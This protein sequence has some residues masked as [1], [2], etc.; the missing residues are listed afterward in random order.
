MNGVNPFSGG[1][2]LPPVGTV[3]G[4]P[5]GVLMSTVLPWIGALLIVIMAWRILTNYL[6][7]NHSGMTREVLFAIVG[8]VFIF[9]PASIGGIIAWIGKMLGTIFGG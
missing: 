8:L 4:S 3:A 9:D 1:N 7:G 2:A 6:K 5:F